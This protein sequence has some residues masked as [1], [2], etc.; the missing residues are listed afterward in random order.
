M[1]TD[2]NWSVQ[3][4]K[5]ACHQSE[6]SDTITGSTDGNSEQYNHHTISPTVQKHK[7]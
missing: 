5:L 1:V 4:N 6:K 2:P 3:K 7:L